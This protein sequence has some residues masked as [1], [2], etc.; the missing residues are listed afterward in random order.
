MDQLVSEMIKGLVEAVTL[1][2]L[3]NL[4]FA[5]LRTIMRHK[6]VS[7]ILYGESTDPDGAVR[8]ALSNPL[9]EIDYEGATGA[10]IHVTG[11]EKLSVK[12]ATKVLS[13]MSEQLDPQAQVIFGARVDPE[14]KD[15]I[16]VMAVITGIKEL[17]ERQANRSHER[18]ELDDTLEEL[19]NQRGR[20]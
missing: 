17:P 15:I 19:V 11:G 12:K 5:D 9:L 7:T 10:L 8:E 3:V 18:E 13:G 14:C 2:S 16:R 20:L 4:D 1:P 6:G